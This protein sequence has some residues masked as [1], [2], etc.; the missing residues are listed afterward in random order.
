L[1]N[2]LTET[3]VT[4]HR[5]SDSFDA[6]EIYAQ[7]PF[8]MPFGARISEIEAKMAQLAGALAARTLV[9]IADNAL[10]PLPQ[11]DSE[12]TY[13]PFPT[14]HDFIISSSWGARRAYAFIRGVATDARP[15]IIDLGNGKK[16]AA[17]D[18]TKW[19]RE[20]GHSAHKAS[21]AEE[22]DIAFVDGVVR[23]RR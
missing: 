12:S 19:F 8:T 18:A 22:I 21:A 5:L 9:T 7:E 23:I 11:C 17:H 3:A 13:A 10:C 16:M 2:G 6:G 15:V 20:Q 1:H 14:M 4:A